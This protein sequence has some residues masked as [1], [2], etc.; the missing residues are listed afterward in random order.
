MIRAAAIGLSMALGWAPTIRNEGGWLSA[1][2]I[3]VILFVVA[4]ILTGMMRPL[5]ESHPDN[6]PSQ[7]GA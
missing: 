5:D 3:L 6:R 7:H 1:F 2:M 4:G